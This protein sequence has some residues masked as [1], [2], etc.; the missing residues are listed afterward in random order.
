MLDAFWDWLVRWRT[1]TV[2]FLFGVVLVPEVVMVLQGFDWGVIVPPKYMP[3][4]TLA[5]AA[6]NIWMRPRP[7]AR[8]RDF[9]GE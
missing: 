1:Y 7:A 6:A 4:V 9:E 2:N 5:L 8:A 3:I